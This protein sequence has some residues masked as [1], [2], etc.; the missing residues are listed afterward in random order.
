MLWQILSNKSKLASALGMI[1]LVTTPIYYKEVTLH[2]IDTIRLYA[3]L[4]AFNFL[5]DFLSRPSYR[6]ATIMGCLVGICLFS[7]HSSGIIA[8]PIFSFIY[9]IFSMSY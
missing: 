9:L 7:A 8:L 3:L 1:L 2:G 4:L 5:A 6:Y